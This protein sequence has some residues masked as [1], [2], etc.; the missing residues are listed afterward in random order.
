[1]SEIS[2]NDD[3]SKIVNNFQTQSLKREIEILDEKL[4]I[5]DQESQKKISNLTNQLAQEKETEIKLRNQLSTKDKAISE[6]NEIIKEYQTELISQKKNMSLKEEKLQEMIVQ[7]NSIKSNCNTISAALNSKE[8]NQ[9]KNELELRKAINDK[10]KIESKIKEL[11]GVVNEYMKQ[12]DELNEKYSNMERENNNLKLINSNLVNENKKLFN[13]NND[14]SKELKNIKET[15]DK[16]EEMSNKYAEQNNDIKIENENLNKQL[17]ENKQRIDSL[18]DENNKLNLIINEFKIKKSK[19]ENDLAMTIEYQKKSNDKHQND[20]Q[21]IISYCN[22]KINKIIKWIDNFFGQANYPNNDDSSQMTLNSSFSDSQYN[23]NFD[24]LRKKLIKVQENVNNDKS[25]IN[26]Y[27]EEAN[28]KYNSFM[29]ERGKYLDILKKIYNTITSEVHT[30]NYFIC[31]YHVNSFNNPKNDEFL[32][33]LN[34][35]EAVI[36]QVLKYLASQSEEK[37]LI[38]NDIEKYKHNIS[39]LQVINDNLTNENNDYKIKIYNNDYSK[40]QENMNILQENYDKCM[41]M[42]QILEKKIKNY[43][44]EFELKQMQINSLEEMVKRRNVNN[45]VNI[46]SENNNNSDEYQP[47]YY[48]NNNSYNSTSF[49]NQNKTIQRLEQD[50]E[51]LIKDNMN[52]IQ[53]NKKLKEQINNLNQIINSLT[54]N[55]NNNN[56]IEQENENEND[57]ENDND[58]NIN[59]E[60]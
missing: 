6:L 48:N 44:T 46:N 41:Q 8:E 60:A 2:T 12:L 13:E 26:K 43:E 20:I 10:I 1:M 17:I 29:I 55:N 18:L 9:K 40:L 57:N 19:M 11:I 32:K 35:V 21:E 37:N 53:Y 14:Y 58:N 7:F 54:M 49:N 25:L 16:C 27:Q 34:L 15:I 50:R 28:E 31:D 22:E 5:L 59:E 24:A 4:R 42:N 30:H 38:M 36:N 51:K 3:I 47:G 52:L 56:N 45:N 23:I 33:L 39:D